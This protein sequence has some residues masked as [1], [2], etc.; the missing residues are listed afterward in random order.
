MNKWEIISYLTNALSFASLVFLIL[1]YLYSNTLSIIQIILISVVCILFSTLIPLAYI[2]FFIEK[3]WKIHHV[4]I[5]YDFSDRKYRIKPLI[6]A[7]LSYGFGTLLLFLLDTPSLIKGLMFCYFIN[8]LIITIIT[9]FWKISVHTAGITGPL[10]ILIYKLGA[11]YLPLYLLVIPVGLARIKLK[12][13]TFVQV[14][15]GALLIIFTTWLQI[16]FIINPM[17]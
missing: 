17:F 8:T 14:V 15:S 6:V 3:E 10:T 12:E 1:I 13:H 7:V 4:R 9:L 11:F 16:I 2:L 5:D